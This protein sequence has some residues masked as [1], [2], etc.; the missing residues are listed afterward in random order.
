MTPLALYQRKVEQK[1]IAFDEVQYQSMVVLDQLFQK[2][3]THKKGFSKF[4]RHFKKTPPIKGVYLWGGVGRG[5]TLL[6]DLFYQSLPFEQKSRLHFYRFMQLVHAFLKQVQGKKD[7]LRILAK[8]F[9]KENRVLCFDEFFVSDIS[10]AMIL[11]RLLKALFEQG[12]TLVATSNL[13]PDLLY[14][15]G[16]Q[17]DKFLPA[18]SLIKTHTQV[19]HL[20]GGNDYRLGHLINAEI[21]HY[22]LDD[23]AEINL[24]KYFHQLSPDKGIKDKILSI[25]SR[26]IPTRYCGQSIVWFTFETLCATPRSAQD[27]IEISRSFNIVLL[28]G[29]KAMGPET[30]DWARRFIMLVDEFYDQHVMLIISSEVP[31]E[32]LYEGRGLAFEF[33]RTRSRLTEMQ[34]K[35][36]LAKQHLS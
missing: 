10:D 17:R 9:A 1:E 25:N 14:V 22:P 29:V 24:E 6:M 21:Y 8:A 7:P 5:K 34:S 20:N 3:T 4:Y 2:L 18:I 13:Q 26:A 33:E 19:L 27:Y 23:N 11:G 16:L 30:E 12:V 31:L 28:S 35:E 36:Y 15:N 32:K